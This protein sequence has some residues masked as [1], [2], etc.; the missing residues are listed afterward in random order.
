MQGKGGQGKGGVR[1]EVRAM[2]VR[3]E[4]KTEPTFEKP[5]KPLERLKD[6]NYTIM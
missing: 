1:R 4:Q 2:A 6:D 5:V 3:W